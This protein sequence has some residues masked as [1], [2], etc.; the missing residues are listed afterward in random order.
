MAAAYIRKGRKVFEMRVPLTRGHGDGPIR[1]L[2]TDDPDVKDDIV[3]LVKR[4][5]KKPEYFPLID[6][7]TMTPPKV[8]LMDVYIADKAN[9]LPELL[10]RLA[11]VDLTLYVDGWEKWVRSNLGDTGTAEMYRA[12]VET[13]ILPDGD[14]SPEFLQ[15]ELTTARVNTWLSE[16]TVTTGYKRKLLYAL[17]SFV[18]Y[19]IE[20]GVFDRN[21]IEHITRPKK[22][23]KRVRWETEE[24]DIRIVRAAVG[25]YQSLF[26]FIK[27]TGAEVSPAT[28][29]TPREIEVW[30][31]DDGRY[32]GFAHVPGTKTETRDRHDVL[33][34]KWARP[35]IERAIQGKLPNAKVWD[36]IS[37]YMAHWHHQNAATAVEIADYTLRDA[38]HSWAVRGRKARPQVTFE[39]IAE[40]LGNTVAVV[41]DV[42]ADFKM[43]PEERIRDG[44]PAGNPATGEEQGA[45]VIPIRESASQ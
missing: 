28:M 2:E 30:P 21:P 15:S 9:R 39:A 29:L 37:R 20:S 41:A 32:C 35:F 11:D 38:R 6:A 16:K 34:E 17:F 14:E 18:R 40:Q 13:L 10:K 27:A 26:A 25:Q 43:T 42:Y 5:L 45:K 24:N 36:G 23:K 33:I 8:S 3:S 22:G 31:K 4:L 19:L 44:A 1:S 7:V 12:Q